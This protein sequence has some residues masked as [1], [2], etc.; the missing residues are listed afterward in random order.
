MGRIVLRL[1]LREIVKIE[2]NQMIEKPEKF[3]Y[4]L[5]SL[6]LW[7]SIFSCVMLYLQGEALE[8]DFGWKEAE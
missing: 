6:F 3:F 5:V 8:A 4:H 2:E 1:R 7:K